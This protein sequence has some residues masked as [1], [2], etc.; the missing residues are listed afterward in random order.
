VQKQINESHVTVADLQQLLEQTSA[1]LVSSQAAVKEARAAAGKRRLKDAAAAAAAALTHGLGASSAADSSKDQQELQQLKVGDAFTVTDSAD[2]FFAQCCLNPVLQ[3]H[4]L[5]A[6][7]LCTCG[8]AKAAVTQDHRISLSPAV[9]NVAL[10]AA[11]CC[12]CCRLSWMRLSRR[13]SRQL[14]TRSK[15]WRSSA[16]HR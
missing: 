4:M 10:A 13:F 8:D 11:G 14:V 16:R 3:C 6:D 15:S 7:L 5:I 12:C 9:V 1:A 2:A